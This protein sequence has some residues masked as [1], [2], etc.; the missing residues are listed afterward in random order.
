VVRPDGTLATHESLR[1]LARDLVVRFAK[2]GLALTQPDMERAL[3][4][5]WDTGRRTGRFRLRREDYRAELSKA[6]RSVQ[7]V[8]WLSRVV[9]LW[10]RWTH[11][12][13]FPRAG[14]SAERL[15]YAIRH[16]CAE[17]RTNRFFLSAR[18]AATITGTTFRAANDTLHRLIATGVIQRASKRL[19]ARQ[20]QAY[21]LL[22]D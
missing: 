4:A 17:A 7:R 1:D 13:D 18:D 15:E 11:E 5:W 14:L 16:H 9:S 3:G 8:P 2:H 12:P 10:L 22:K 21:R 20:A 6:I 19:H